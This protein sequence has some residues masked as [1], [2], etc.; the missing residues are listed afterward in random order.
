M[1]IP[2]IGECVRESQ[3]EIYNSCAYAYDN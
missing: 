1:T 2:R 3:I